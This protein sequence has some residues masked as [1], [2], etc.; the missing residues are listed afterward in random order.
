MVLSIP[1]ADKTTLFTGLTIPHL[2][3][4][5]II[6]FSP[7]NRLPLRGVRLVIPLAFTQDRHQRLVRCRSLC[8]GHGFPG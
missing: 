7:W 2:R 5:M 3:R 4:A 1:I 6:L 8:F